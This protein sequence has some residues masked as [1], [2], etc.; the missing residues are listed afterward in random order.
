M[1][2]GKTWLV[3]IE[4]TSQ[5][6]VTHPVGSLEFNWIPKPSRTDGDNVMS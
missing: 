4:P 2:A 1:T 6:A 5:V 3:K